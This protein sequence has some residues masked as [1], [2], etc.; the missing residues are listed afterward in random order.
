MHP[1]ILFLHVHVIICGYLQTIY[2]LR[3]RVIHLIELII[4]DLDKTLLN[5][6]KE[7]SSYT[8]E[9]LLECRRKKGIKVAFATARPERATK[10][11]Q[12]LIQPD[13]V[14]SNN[15][16]T[17]S[18][19]GNTI[20][21][22]IIPTDV[23]NMLISNLV[24]MRDVIWLTAEAGACLYTNYKGEPWDTENWNPVYNDFSEQLNEDISKISIECK[25]P[26]LINTLISEFPNLHLY[27]NSGE[28][29][30]QVMHVKSTKMNAALYLSEVL[31]ISCRNF[32]AFGDD[33]NDIEL[34]KKSGTGVAVGNAI[35][36]VKQVAD[37]ISLSNNNDGVAKW[38]EE[39]ILGLHGA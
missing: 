15:G 20:Y 18:C 35:E 26:E 25:K 19:N 31:K 39:N 36:S 10:G 30:C 3:G 38:L 32:V 13:Y 6:K 33:Y 14:I 7:L 11:F 23:C 34:I 16:A 5:D 21:N 22:N 2:I 17:I 9:V 4:T 28:D 37:F 8:E 1:L 24:K 27:T 29:W 12:Q